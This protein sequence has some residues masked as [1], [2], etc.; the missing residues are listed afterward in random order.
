MHEILIPGIYVLTGFMVYA[1][2]YHF[3]MALYRPHDPVQLLFGCVCLFVLPFAIFHV[4]MLR[5]TDVA[6]FVSAL[7]WSLSSAILFFM[8]L[9]WFIAQYSG[10]RPLGLL[11]GL[12]ILFVIA[13]AVNL[14]QPFGVQYSQLNG[15]E[16]IRLP[17]GETVTRGTG[18]NGFWAYYTIALAAVGFGY[19]LYALTWKLRASR[20]LA[21]MMML[22]SAGILLIGTTTG[23]LAR[24]SILKFIETGPVDLLAMVVVMSLALIRDTRDRLENSE[25][26]FRSLFEN[27]PTSI[28]AADAKDFRIVQANPAALQMSGYSG[29]EL[30]SRT[31]AD[32][33][34]PDDFDP[35]AFQQNIVQFAAGVIDRLSHEK[36][37]IRKDGSVFI[38]HSSISALK[39]SSGKLLRFIGSTIDVTERNRAEEQVTKLT[40]W[41]Q[42]LL[43]SA[44]YGIIS[45]DAE[46]VIVSFNVAAQ[47]MLGYLPEEL[48]G[49][50]SPGIFHDPDE[51]A[52][53]AAEL[54]NELGRTV[55]PGFDVFVA[56]TGMGHAEE[57][58]WTYIRKNG[59]RLPVRL[60]VTALHGS[61]GKITGYMGIAAD[62]TE[63]KQAQS[64]L[65]D[66]DSRYRTLFD[67]A[68]DSI[69]LMEGERFVDCNPAT[70]S[71][72]GCTREQ[73]IGEP[74]YRY[75][76]ESQPDGRPSKQKALD[77]IAAA[78]TGGTP[79]F[80][81]QH[82]RYDGT[83]FD[84][85]V[86][87]NAVEIG[88]K[89]CLL[90]F[91]RDV[92]K[93]KRAE[94][95]VLNSE[96]KLRLLFENM[97]TGFALHEVICDEQGKA[98]DYRFLEI[99]PAYE[100][101]TGLKASDII[102]RSVLEVL[103]D[104]ESYWIESF[105][106]VALTGEP[107]V[108]ENYS[109]E[110]GRWFHARAFSPKTGQF[111]V[112]ISD[113]TEQK[114]ADQLFR[115]VFQTS[116]DAI[117]ITYAKNG[118]YYEVNQAF[119]DITGFGRDEVIG[120]TGLE[121][122]LWADPT[123]RQ[124][125]VETIQRE[126][127]VRNQEIQLLKKGGE[128]MWALI[129]ASMFE[130]DG[131]PYFLSITHDITERKLAEEKIHQMAFHDSLTDLPN[132]QLL[133]D[134]MGQA[135]ASSARSGHKGAVLFIDLDN[136]KSINDTL[137]HPIGNLL[138]QHVTGRLTACVRGGD[139]VARLGGDEFVVMLEDLG[140]QTN[141]VAE[142]TE[143]VG[144]KI[145]GA[146]RRPFQLD[147]HELHIT[148]SIGATVFGGDGQDADELLKQADI[149]MY[150]AKK[151]GRNTLRF[152][153]PQ[154]QEAINARVSLESE[155]RKALEHRHF[156]LY[157]QVQVDDSD[158]PV[159]AE[160][161]IRWIHPERG[162]VSPLQFIPIAEETGLIVP[163]GLW[164]MDAA[165]AQ[166]RSWQED[167]LTMGLTLAVNVSARQIRQA[168]F[169]SQVEDCVQ[170]H[171]IIPRRL[172][173]EL[174]ESAL[175]EDIEEI[176]ATM[177]ALR[178]IGVQFSLDDFGT[179]FSSLQY[180]KKLPLDQIKID[181]SFVRDIAT[182]PNDATIVQTIIAMAEAL[183][184]SVIAE[185]VE[186]EAQR[187]FLDLRGCRVYQ[188]YLFGK[189]MPIDQFGEIPKHG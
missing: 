33:T 65:R 56:K 169:V 67:S 42:T 110:L 183:G 187:E 79:T 130:L 61:S 136:F 1:M 104:T 96:N 109:K 108:L 149:A 7:K 85:E 23:I 68:G 66:S 107:A 58:E 71:M 34:H 137:G 27:S 153:D 102:D 88:E 82:C 22:F 63:S 29:E 30:R 41:Q 10:K 11:I 168:D 45:T 78:L 158:F 14:T 106:K 81:W 165:C 69:L 167:E 131:E 154:M 113:V 186:S 144:E 176:V 92:S 189:P 26:N 64:R 112:M 49:K 80:D 121:L 24:L 52:R 115:E 53:R 70:L 62:L 127:E 174:T 13:L 77:K 178:A 31:I 172:K 139:T 38:G 46:G 129:S 15:I 117:N 51:V 50:H 164:V 120:R 3:A 182:D 93:R 122:N 5:A 184:L 59:S 151:D 138:L 152:F 124:R 89:A 140:T 4:Q 57:R 188:G 101:L 103:P 20:K 95:E 148:T 9:L 166:L 98:T 118:R 185:G 163:I 17:W 162:L 105:G 100:R 175:L 128:T 32:L 123:Q 126:G 60:S 36:R 87:L 180:L 83:L 171:G 76:P 35:E 134:R 39:D 114:R 155:L 12:S 40:D 161:L 132:R 145:L 179:G 141:D 150:Q 156:Q 143:G 6:D 90:A 44:D 157:Y 147:R 18:H 99:N 28:V 97:T 116:L 181:Q 177:N 54:S 2:Y 159:G 119:Q 75:S 8:L 94:L 160:A 72:F 48:I 170:R 19:V 37:Y 84:A 142:Q 21:D 16:T 25:R 86:S 91:V 173:L 55:L 74:P 133:L 135:M 111:A 125:L 73:I 47:R 146:L 43:D